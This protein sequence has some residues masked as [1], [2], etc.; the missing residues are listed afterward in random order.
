MD[1]GSIDHLQIAT[2]TN[3][4]SPTEPHSPVITVI[5]A[6]IEVNCLLYTL[7]ANPSLT[8]VLVRTLLDSSGLLPLTQQRPNLS[9]SLSLYITTDGQSASLSWNKAPVW[10]LRPDFYYC[11]TVAALM[12]WGD[13]SDERTGLS[14]TMAVGPRRRSHFR[15]RVPW[16]S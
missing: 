9:R 15:V 7:L 10:G 8:S 11:L 3:Y 6:H 13:L 4:N 5:T 1:I 14:F 16:D 12:M 2:T